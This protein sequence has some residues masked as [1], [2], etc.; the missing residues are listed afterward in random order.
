MTT[1]HL[2]KSIGRSS[3]RLAFLLIPLLFACFALCPI[4]QAVTPAP[5]G[6]YP[7]QNTAEGESALNSLTTGDKNTAIGFKALFSNAAGN[8]NTAIGAGALRDNSKASRN[9]AVGA[10]AI[11][12]N[13]TGEL[14]TAIGNVALES[15]TSGGVNTALGV[16]ALNRN[17]TGDGNTAIGNSALNSNLGGN[18]NTALGVAAL[19]HNTTGSNNIAIGHDALNDLEDGNDNTAIGE[20]TLSDMGGGEGNT[21]VGDGALVNSLGNFNTA[22]GQDAGKAVALV[23]NVI[24]IGSPGANVGNSCFIGQIRGVMTARND[25][26]PVVI[27]SAG[28]LGTMSSSKRFKKDIKP[29]ES[30]SNS[31]L[32]LEPVTFHYKSDKSNTPQFGLIAEEVA[33]VNP[34]LVVRDKDGQIYTVR[35]DAVNA[36][37]L[38]EFLKEH[39]QVEEQQAT[40]TQLNLT[41]AQ[42][43]KDFQGTVAKLN[44]RLDDQTSQIQKVSAQLEASKPAPQTVANNQ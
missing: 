41:V 38:N 30:T 15:N 18:L 25:A 4:A 44:A 39:K 5:D 28:Q 13:T 14:N 6:D 17:T 26:L 42:Q 43:K 22:L 29:M 3:S 7:G 35:Y 37:L 16:A 23:S 20:N 1:L 8:F 24:C 31:I 34:N 9:T 11:A 40:I 36:M 21:A 32:D 12:N 19:G 10:F 33:K 27:D 2:R